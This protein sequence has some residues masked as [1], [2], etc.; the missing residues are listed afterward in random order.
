MPQAEALIRAT[1][2][3]QRIG[4]NSAF[5]VP[6]ADYIQVPPP[7]AYVEPINWHRTVCHE[8]GHWTGASHRLNRDFSGGFGSAS[9]AREGL[10]AE[11]PAPLCA[12]SSRSCRPCAMPIISVR[13]SRCCARII[14]PSS[15]RRALH[16]KQPIICSRF[17]A[18]PL[19]QTLKMTTVRCSRRR[20]RPHRWRQYEIV[21]NR[22]RRRCYVGRQ[23]LA[24]VGVEHREALKE[25]DRLRVVPDF[26]RARALAVG[27]EA[28]GINEGGA[29]FAL[30]DHRLLS[31]LVGWR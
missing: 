18:P 14:A 5:Y 23:T 10:V 31:K 30:A 25:G 21:R 20:H 2:A 6:S 22:L 8:L 26:R 24:L 7:S 3:E 13:G 9:Y 27:N 12:P 19:C 1:G 28:V 29:L 17:V 15:A 4:G 16:P 11:R